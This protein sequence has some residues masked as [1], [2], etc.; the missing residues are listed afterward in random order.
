[1]DHDTQPAFDDET[2][3][4]VMQEQTAC[5]FGHEDGVAPRCRWCASRAVWIPQMM[6]AIRREYQ[7]MEEDTG[8]GVYRD[9]DCDT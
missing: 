3:M 2:A 4:V 6:A 7:V 8:D 9:T 5:L 1:M